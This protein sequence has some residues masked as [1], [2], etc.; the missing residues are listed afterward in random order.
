MV[1]FK[2]LETLFYQHKE[3]L[4]KLVL[5]FSGGKGLCKIIDFFIHT[6]SQAVIGIKDGCCKTKK[7]Y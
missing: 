5:F 1:K 4:G 7:Q 6:N 2:S 3:F